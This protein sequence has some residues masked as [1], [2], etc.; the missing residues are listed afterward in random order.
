MNKILLDKV[1]KAK[2]EVC[3]FSRRD[4]AQQTVLIAGTAVLTSKTINVVGLVFDSKLSWGPQVTNAISKSSKALNAIRL[5]SRYFNKKELIQL[6]TSNY[7]SILFFNSE[8]WHINNLK[9]SLKSSLLTASSK[10]LKVCLKNHDPFVSYENL[11]KMAKRATPER[12]MQYKLSL[13]LFKTYNYHT[14]VTDWLYLNENIIL[15]SRQQKFKIARHNRLRLGNNSLSSRLW[16]LND[17]ISLNWLNLS[18]E[19]FKIKMKEMFITY[20]DT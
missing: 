5:I 14:P 1:N 18:F 13:Q 4:V 8:V 7:Y 2:T 6:I 17:K 15:T 20:N 12:L 16:Y 11:H 10:A 19:T 3:L 9:N